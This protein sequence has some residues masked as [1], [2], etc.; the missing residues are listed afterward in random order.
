MKGDSPTGR[1]PNTIY[2]HLHRSGKTFGEVSKEKPL[3]QTDYS[4]LELRIAAAILGVPT[5][6]TP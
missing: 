1:L 3:I 2:H 4:A 5:R 6:H